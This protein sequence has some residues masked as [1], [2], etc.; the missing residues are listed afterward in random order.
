MDIKQA[1]P[2]NPESIKWSPIVD[3]LITIFTK[4]H[5]SHRDGIRYNVSRAVSSLAFLYEKAR[6]AVEFRAEHL[7]RRAATERIFKRRILLNGG[8]PNIAE[9]LIL[10]L[11]WARYIDSSLVD[12]EK[13]QEIQKIID[14]YVTLKHLVF[15]GNFKQKHVSWDT[16]AGIASSEID[17]AIVSPRKR[18]ALNEFFYQAIRPMISIPG[19]D[20]R[21]VNMQTYI[22]VERAYAQADDP[23]I[24]FHLLKLIYPKWLTISGQDIPQEQENFLNTVNIIIEGLKDPMN[25]PVNRFIRRHNP[26]FLLIRDFFMEK[27]AKAREIMENSLE[28]EKSLA[29]IASHRYQEIGKKIR[30]AVIRSIIYIFL[31]KMVFAIALEAPFDIFITKKVAYIPLAI[32]MIVP[33]ILLYLI[34]GLIN[35]PGAENTRV[36]IDRIKKIIYHFDDLKNGKNT[37]SISQIDRRPLLTA[38]F[39]VI[40]LIT[41]LVSFGAITWVLTKFS[42]N[43]A[44]QLIFIFFIA[45]VSFFAYRI[46]T[47]AKEYEMVERQG[48]IEPVVDLF[49]LPILRAGQWLS[50]EIAKINI[51]II[52]FDFILEAPLKVIFELFEE[53]I[54][55]I[56]T[57]KEEII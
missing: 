44:S 46:R 35:V 57:K 21:Y 25:I 22:G 20:E 5:E 36:V 28:F 39:T 52:L 15:N 10:E 7:V 14:K 8:V 3:E 19:K 55:F 30:R 13:T 37:F 16:I 48:I 4:D 56:R 54:R 24:T 41:F 40:Y 6:N 17:E 33:P 47:S 51:F 32:N 34:A 27:G 1:E 43:I 42:F 45:L 2:N 50:G 29:E 18:E 9:N 31:T 26:P 12:E 53:W 23:L 38:I 11:V 49:F